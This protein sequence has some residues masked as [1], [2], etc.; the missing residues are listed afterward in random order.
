MGASDQHEMLAS[1]RCLDPIGVV[2]WP[3]PSA[4]IF[5]TPSV[6][7]GQPSGLPAPCALSRLD[8]P[9]SSLF[10][11]DAASAFP[12]NHLLPSLHLPQSIPSQH[13]NCTGPC[14]AQTA[15]CRC[16]LP[17]DISQSLKHFSGCS[18][19]G[20][21]Q[22][23]HSTEC[24]KNY[25]RTDQAKASSLSHLQRQGSSGSSR[26][27]SAYQSTATLPQ[28]LQQVTGHGLFLPS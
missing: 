1:C 2:P 25:Y 24:K 15:Y 9:S 22:H 17:K 4:H 10:P 3:R 6:A 12:K 20:G 19:C 21:P 5:L 26:A 7:E 14:L 13:E 18:C 11:G 23:E 8:C 27:T 16:C 28:N